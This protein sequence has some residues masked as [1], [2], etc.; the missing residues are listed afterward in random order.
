MIDLFLES[1]M[2][3][4]ASVDRQQSFIPIIDIGPLMRGVEDR[5]SVAAEIGRAC[6]ECGFFYIVGH[7]VDE[8]MQQRLEELSRQFFA[9]DLAT[10]MELRM[11]RGGQAWRG[12][13]PVGGELTSGQ[14]DM[15]EGL[16]F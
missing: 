13:F 12:Y 4:Q 15:K 3:T 5:L 10:K 8:G 14:P 9:Q 11:A 16:Y 2:N 6:R 7:G 1:R